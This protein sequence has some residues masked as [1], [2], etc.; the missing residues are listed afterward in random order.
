MGNDEIKNKLVSIL[1]SQQAQGRTPEQAVE[2]ILQALGGRAGDVS[3]ISVLTSTLIADVLYTVYQ[4]TI[5]YRQIALLLRKLGYADR[6]IAVALHASYPQ[7][8]TQDV[9]ELFIAP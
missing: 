6:D 3:R 5:T 4:E 2:N 8:T 9:D 7:L 1:A